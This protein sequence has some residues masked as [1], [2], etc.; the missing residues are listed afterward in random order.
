MNLK[1]L[2]KST[3]AICFPPYKTA[4]KRLAAKE[5]Q[6]CALRK[7]RDALQQKLKRYDGETF[8]KQTCGSE[9]FPPEGEVCHDYY[10]EITSNCNLHCRLCAHGHR[11]MFYRNNG[12]MGLALFEEILEKIKQESPSARVLPYQYCEPL[13]NPNLSEFVKAIKRRGFQTS[14]ASNFNYVRDIHGVKHS[15]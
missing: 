14:I 1:S 15:A 9:F 6:V 4:Q 5:Q 3:V 11:E 7:E 10:I 2:I 8:L 13:L 12:T